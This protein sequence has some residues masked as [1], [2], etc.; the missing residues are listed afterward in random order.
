MLLFLF[1]IYL[2]SVPSREYSCAG[3][4]PRPVFKQRVEEKKNVRKA[5]KV[6][7]EGKKTIYSEYKN[8]GFVSFLKHRASIGAC[9]VPV[10]SCHEFGA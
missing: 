10:M 9:F 4:R 3:K 8:L 6:T 1:L 7:K 5:L 2:I